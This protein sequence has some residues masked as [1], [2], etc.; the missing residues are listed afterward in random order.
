MNNLTNIV[1]Y[2][3]DEAMLEEAREILLANR[4]KIADDDT[5]SL[6]EDAPVFNYLRI[7]HDK[8]WY[9]SVKHINTEITLTELEN[10]LKQNIDAR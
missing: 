1:V 7:F 9:L 3:N 5:F 2:I 8:T 6:E 10:L 4:Q